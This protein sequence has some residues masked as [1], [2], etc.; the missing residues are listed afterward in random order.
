MYVISGS[1]MNEN[2]DLYP[3]F[4]WAP[5]PFYCFPAT[6]LNSPDEPRIHYLRIN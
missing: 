4:L 5:S 6:F 3:L 1:F 2:E